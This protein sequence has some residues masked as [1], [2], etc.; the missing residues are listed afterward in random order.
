MIAWSLAT[1]ALVCVLPGFVLGWVNL[2]RY[3]RAPVDGPRISTSVSICIPA[4]NEAGNIEA[5]IR[6]ALRSG[7]EAGAPE[8]EV[9]V[10]DDQSEDETPTILARLAAEDHRVRLV[11]TVPLPS[12]WNGKQHACE[13][14]GRAAGTEWL[15]FTDAD[16]RF[17]PDMLRRTV[18]AREE[19]D[20]ELI[21]TVPRELTGTIGEMLLIPLINWILLCY[22][23]F[24]MMRKTLRSSASAAVGQFIFC[25]RNSWVDSGGHAAFRDSMH[26]GV[27]MPR[28]FREA[29]H[30]TDLFDGTELVSCRMYEGFT[31]TW[32]G[33]AKNAFE[34]LGSVGLLVMVTILHAVGHL[35]PWGLLGWL[36]FGGEPL[37]PFL[38]SLVLGTLLL[39]FI[40]RAAMARRF[41]QSPLG[42]FVH[43]FAITCLIAVQ[44]WSYLL[45]RSGRRSWRGRLATPDPS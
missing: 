10:Y 27:K 6:S 1:A 9:L 11:P 12:G 13:R 34:G 18:L 5:C 16:V 3:R 39:P 37:D 38:L 35:L 45:D 31:E 32:R 24:G 43:P 28:A 22:L 19:L 8:L 21:S 14:M 40:Q 7:D 42:V 2:R 29:G 36:L 44:W 30:R 4:R 41:Q 25:R 20:A 23:P 33:F 17:S 26:D 15:L